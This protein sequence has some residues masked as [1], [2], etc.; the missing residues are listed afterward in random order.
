[1]TLTSAKNDFMRTLNSVPGLLGKI[2][3]LAT[4][5]NEV[6][7]Y[8]HWGFEK[9]HGRELAAESI[10]TAHK[11]IF[12]DVLRS[13]ILELWSEIESLADGNEGSIEGTMNRLMD[14]KTQAVPE[15][16]CRGPR[17][18]F[19]AVVEAVSA[20]VAAQRQSSRRAA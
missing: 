11:I 20:L 2:F 5:R 14:L 15:R 12:T 13:P 3:Y 16:A 18:H 9:I 8:E 4:L 1:M 19:N 10:S 17:I 7:E 6:G